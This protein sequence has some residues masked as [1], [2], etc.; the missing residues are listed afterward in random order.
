MNT[1]DSS[2][3]HVYLR[4]N[5]QVKADTARLLSEIASDMGISID[6]LLSF[7]AEDAVIDLAREEESTN[8]ITIPDKCSKED[9]LEVIKKRAN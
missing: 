1:Q 9:L 3:F 8:K 6:D 2:A 5:I 7:L 4:A